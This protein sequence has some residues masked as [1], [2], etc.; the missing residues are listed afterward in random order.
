MNIEKRPMPRTV[1]AFGEAIVG[2][3]PADCRRPLAL[4]QRGGST[5]CTC[6]G[7]ALRLQYPCTKVSDV[8]PLLLL[9]DGACKIT[10]YGEGC[11]LPS[12]P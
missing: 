12:T 3:G 2:Q 6:K 9:D 5:N 10:P 8:L 4:L 7:T 1:G 11:P